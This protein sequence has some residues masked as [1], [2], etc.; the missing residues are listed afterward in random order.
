MFK[1]K[2]QSTEVQTSSQEAYT[3]AALH[4]EKLNFHESRVTY[5]SRA[6]HYL[7]GKALVFTYNWTY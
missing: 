3:A 6:L 1:M 2:S 5:G 4:N 7:I